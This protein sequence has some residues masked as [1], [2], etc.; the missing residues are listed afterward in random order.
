MAASAAHIM[1][2]LRDTY[3]DVRL[4]YYNIPREVLEANGIGPLDVDN[5]AYRAW[6]KRRVQ[7]SRAYFDAGRAYLARVP[8]V[9][10]RLAGLA[11]IARFEW[12][13]EALEAENFRLRPEYSE[14]HSIGTALRMARLPL[15]GMVHLSHMRAP[16]RPIASQPQGKL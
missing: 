16:V 6:V 8:N 3:D 9:R 11:Y 15:S 2:M 12:L 1:H 7:L 4:G 14:R 10:Y 5:D 13:S